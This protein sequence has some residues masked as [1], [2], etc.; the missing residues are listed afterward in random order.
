VRAGARPRRIFPVLRALF[1]SAALFGLVAWHVALTTWQA[2]LERVQREAQTAQERY[3][4]LRLEVAELEAP[5]RVV[6]VA[7]RRLGMVPPPQ[8][9]YLSPTGDAPRPPSR[10]ADVGSDRAGP[11]TSWPTVKAHLAE[12]P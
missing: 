1:V 9:T 7:Q 8:V 2:H 11:G 12:R 3:E 4:R 10:A 6:A 5:E